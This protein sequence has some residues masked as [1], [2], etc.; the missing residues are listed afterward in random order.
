MSRLLHSPIHQVMWYV[1]VFIV[2]PFSLLWVP[3]FSRKLSFLWSPC[4]LLTLIQS[5]EILLVNLLWGFSWK[6]LLLLEQ[7]CQSHLMNLVQLI[8]CWRADEEF[9]WNNIS[10]IVGKEFWYGKKQR[11]SWEFIWMLFF[12]IL[13]WLLNSLVIWSL[14]ITASTILKYCD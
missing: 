3:F 8:D 13:L 12:L 6:L 10:F 2:N 7:Y 1:W 11:F 5:A 4:L 14:N 9:S